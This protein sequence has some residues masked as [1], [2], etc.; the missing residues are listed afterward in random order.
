MLEIFLFVNPLGTDCRQAEAAVRR[1]QH[2]SLEKVDLHVAM[3]LNFQVVTASLVATH[4]DPKDLALRNQL[5]KAA[6]EV[7][8][9]FKAAQL[10]GNHKARQLL[11]GEQ[12]MFTDGDFT[13]DPAFAMALVSGYGLNQ[14]AFIDD[15]KRLAQ[16]PCIDADQQLASQM[17]VTQAPD[18]VVFDTTNQNPGVRL[19]NTRNYQRLKAVCEK[20]QLTPPSMLHV[21]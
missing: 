12:E 5:T 13:Y 3:L 21:L 1:L 15:R 2:E 11:L 9:D 18:V 16:T 7:A 20:L 19:G 17:G 6:Y 14:A 10:Q 4:R 8:L